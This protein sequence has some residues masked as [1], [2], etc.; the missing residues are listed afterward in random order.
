MTQRATRADLIRR[1]AAATVC[2][3]TMTAMCVVIVALVPGA[4]PA[5]RALLAFALTPYPGT[6][7]ELVDIATTNTRVVL[8]IALAAWAPSRAP[9]L[10]TPADLLVLTI[11]VANT[12]FVGSAVG[13]YAAEAIPWLVHLPVEWAAL[14]I[15]VGLYATARRRHVS[16]TAWTAAT[17]AALALVVAGALA[18]T[19]L[20][21]QW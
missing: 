18:E 17:T 1:I 15:V 16:L 4:R 21:P 9:A 20:T 11:V 5:V 10:R 3:W 19:F 6:P 13:A 2:L 12:A 8:G 14:A 7:Q